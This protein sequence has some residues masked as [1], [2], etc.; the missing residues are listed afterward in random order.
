MHVRFASRLDL[1]PAAAVLRNAARRLEA[2][3]SPLWNPAQF[4]TS[5]LEPI[6]AAGELCVAVLE[7]RVIGVMFLQRS[8]PVFWADEP[9]G[10]SLFVHKLVVDDDQVGKGISKSLLEFAVVQAR[11]SA[12]AWVRLDCA[13]R[14]KLRAVYEGFGF[15]HRDTRNVRVSSNEVFTVCR[16]ELAV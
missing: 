13:D 8:D 2:A 14:A 4:N 3:G 7:E 5:S 16:Y 9:E 10:S 15:R 1:E 12:R 11:S 6:Q